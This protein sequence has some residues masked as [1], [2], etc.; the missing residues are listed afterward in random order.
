MENTRQV[1][2]ESAL[3]YAHLGL[4]VI[5]LHGKRPYFENWYDVATRD[6]NTI[7]HWWTQNHND[8]IGIVTGI[9]SQVFVVDVDPRNG[10][11]DSIDTLFTRHG[12]FPTTWEAM[13]GSGGRHYYFRMPAFPVGNVVGFAPGIDIKGT[14]GQVVAP[15]SIHPDTGKRYEWDGL[16]DIQDE[17]LAE[18]PRWLLDA[19]RERT[20][21]KKA[22]SPP[23]A[24]KIPKG[25]QHITLVSLAGRLRMTCPHDSW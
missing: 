14:G 6:E 11:E 10:G 8:N 18:A 2:L 24:L 17:P 22:T 19:V 23:I 21:S 25:V 15:P 3:E 20:E 4:S 12:R 7:Q 16:N 1:L 5:P 9:K 13:T